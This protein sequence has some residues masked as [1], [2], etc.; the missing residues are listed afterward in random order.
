[1]KKK[2]GLIG[3]KLIGIKGARFFVVWRGKN[4]DAG[5][6]DEEGKKKRAESVEQRRAGLA[7]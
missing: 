3:I 7:W 6:G 1:M 5:L 4:R 2:M